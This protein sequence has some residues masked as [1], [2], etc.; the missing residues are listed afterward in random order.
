MGKACSKRWE[1]GN[2]Y[3]LLVEEQNGKSNSKNLGQE[4]DNF[5]M[6]FKGETRKVVGSGSG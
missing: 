6:D 4:W 1:K 2:A 5:K 3:K